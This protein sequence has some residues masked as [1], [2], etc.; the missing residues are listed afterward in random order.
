MGYPNINS[1]RNQSIDLREIVKYLKL[2]YIVIPKT[3]I[4][5][6]FPSQQFVWTTLRLGLGKIGTVTGDSLIKFVWKGFTCTR[7]T[8]LE[9]NN[10]ECICS[11][12]IISG[13]KWACFSIYRPPY[14][15]NIDHLF[16]E[17]SD[18]FSK[19]NRCV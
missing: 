3:K 5:E 17:L 1:L 15:Q 2:D 12:L 9:P 16:Y 19:A 18:S 13:K 7:L 6:W 11:S 10:V 8:N 14:S 4:D